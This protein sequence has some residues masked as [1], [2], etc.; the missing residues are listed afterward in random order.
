MNKLVKQRQCDHQTSETLQC[1]RL[2]D[3]NLILCAEVVVRLDLLKG[4]VVLQVVVETVVEEENSVVQLV[5]VLIFLAGVLLVEFELSVEG[6][7][8]LLWD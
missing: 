3:S 7:M 5:R 6:E 4:L 8:S 1:F 2:I